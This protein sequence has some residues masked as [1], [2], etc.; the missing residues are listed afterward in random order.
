MVALRLLGTPRAFPDLPPRW[1]DDLILWEAWK[2]RIAVTHL[3]NSCDGCGLG[4][5]L[6]Q[7]TGWYARSSTGTAWK[8]RGMR[9]FR[10][11]RC[12]WCGHTTVFTMHDEQAWTLDESDYRP[13]GSYV[14][15]D[16]ERL[17]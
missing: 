9:N 12:G 5:S 2:K 11:T 1:D 3:D 17:F 14:T 10:S 4:S 6:W 16:M 13:E 7:A 15:E 8:R